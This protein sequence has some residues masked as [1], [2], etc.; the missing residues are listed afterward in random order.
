MYTPPKLEKACILKGQKNQPREGNGVE[1][2]HQ[3]LKNYT[4]L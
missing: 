3:Q 4:E 1:K 2:I